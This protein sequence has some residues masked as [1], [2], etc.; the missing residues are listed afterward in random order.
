MVSLTAV[1]TSNALLPTTLP[2]VVAVF[3]GA[4]S[5][6]GEYSLKAFAKNTRQPRA[7]FIGRS[8]EAGNRIKA[9]CHALNPQGE[10]IF[11]KSDTSL[12]RNVDSICDEIKKKEKSINI[13]FL[14]TGTF[15]QTG[16]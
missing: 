15:A 10:F 6:I 7:Y 5:G 13:L 2:G 14:T 8:Q 9:E 11:M 3:V 16:E 1:R 12:I 4:T